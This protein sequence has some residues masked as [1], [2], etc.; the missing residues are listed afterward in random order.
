MRVISTTC[1]GAAKRSLI[2]GTRLWPPAR[3]LPSPPNSATR[4]AASFTVLATWYSNDCGIILKPPSGIGNR[5]SGVRRLIKCP[6]YRL[7]SARCLLLHQLPDFFGL[8][9]HVDMPHAKRPK[10]I[11]YRIHHGWRGADRS[12][13]AHAFRAQRIHG[14][15]RFGAVV[16]KPAEL[17]GLGHGVIHQGAGQ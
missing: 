7:E 8:E 12:S 11:H 10:R 14:R 4:R 9:R 2:M 17:M 16:V 5:E 3:I 15:R 1:L 6:D 13:F